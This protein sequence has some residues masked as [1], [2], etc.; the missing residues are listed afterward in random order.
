MKTHK[1]LEAWKKALDFVTDVYKL[2]NIFP[3]D[4]RCG[5]TP[6]KSEEQQCLFLPTSQKEQQETMTKNSFNFFILH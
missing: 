5:L 4:E 3:P 6:T 1:D 2:T